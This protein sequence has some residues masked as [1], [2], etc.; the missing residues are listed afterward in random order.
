M[1]LPC[2]LLVVRDFVLFDLLRLRSWLLPE[3]VLCVLRRRPHLRAEHVR[4][5]GLELRL[6][7]KKT[8]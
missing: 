3:G 1:R 2:L 7:S 4:Q 6:P 5:V 8:N